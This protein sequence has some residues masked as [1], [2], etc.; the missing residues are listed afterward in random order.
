M[1]VWWHF[2]AFKT[3]VFIINQVDAFVRACKQT[4]LYNVLDA[5]TSSNVQ[6]GLHFTAVT[7][8]LICRPRHTFTAQSPQVTQTHTN[9]LGYIVPL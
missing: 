6:V 9:V 5:L 1:C 2:R 4:L 8:A 3:V 7:T